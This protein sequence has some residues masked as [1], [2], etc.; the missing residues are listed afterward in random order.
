MVSQEGLLIP[1]LSTRKCILIGTLFHP[2]N[3]SLWAFSHYAYLV[4]MT[5]WTTAQ[6][7]DGN[8][9]VRFGRKLIYTTP[10]PEKGTA[11][12]R[13]AQALCREAMELADHGDFGERLSHPYTSRI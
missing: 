6:F 13:K 9:H 7:H 12:V 8:G 2:Q 4:A 3:S 11:P 1:P 5:T 10:A